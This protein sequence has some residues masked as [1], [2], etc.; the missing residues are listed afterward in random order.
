MTWAKV[1][2]GGQREIPEAGGCGQ[3]SSPIG[4][5]CPPRSGASMPKG[6]IVLSPDQ[7]LQAAYSAGRDEWYFKLNGR[8]AQPGS[9]GRPAQ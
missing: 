8:Y 3:K 5:F 7:Q 9:V 2:K 6:K 1:G 4:G